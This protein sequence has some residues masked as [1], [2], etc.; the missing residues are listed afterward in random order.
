MVEP[1][2]QM[3]AAASQFSKGRVR[4]V[5]IKTTAKEVTQIS[6]ASPVVPPISATSPPA[7]SQFSRG[8][9]RRI[10]IKMPAE[11]VTQISSASPVVPRLVD[12]VQRLRRPA[13]VVVISVLNFVVLGL[14]LYSEFELFVNLVRRATETATSS[15]PVFFAA[16]LFLPLLLL[17]AGIGGLVALLLV[18]LQIALFLVSGIG[19]LGLRKWS[20][21]FAAFNGA[22]C[23]V[24][25]VAILVWML[26]WKVDTDAG[27]YPVG[28]L[29]PSAWLTA[30]VM[31]LAG[32]VTLFFLLQ[33]SF[34][35]R[36][37]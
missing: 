36:F 25:G 15:Y 30:L 8:R 22:L 32:L 20:L 29:I 34:H 35:A 17:G 28:L 6:S 13:S 37:R 3:S 18:A 33:R 4:W 12:P 23:L 2:G 9:V 10:P 5:R 26:I 11:E 14:L 16:L 19:I 1:D 24:G 21:V 31:V 27:T 7:A